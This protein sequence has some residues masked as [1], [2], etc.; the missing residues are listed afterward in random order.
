MGRFRYL[1]RNSG[2]RGASTSA[3]EIGAVAV[4]LQGVWALVPNGLP[5]SWPDVTRRGSRYLSLMQTID[6]YA[7]ATQPRSL[8]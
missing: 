6:F 2:C 3:P 5:T 7:D 8:P 4:D 1:M